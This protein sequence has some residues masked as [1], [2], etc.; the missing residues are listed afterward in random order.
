MLLVLF[1]LSEYIRSAQ[2]P[3]NLEPV[4]EEN[5]QDLIGFKCLEESLSIF[6]VET[7]NWN[8]NSMKAALKLNRASDRKEFKS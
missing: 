2:K 8:P 7:F 1:D 6:L 5:N 4:F 3:N